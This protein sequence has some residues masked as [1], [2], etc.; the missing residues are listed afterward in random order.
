[1]APSKQYGTG[2]HY[3][4]PDAPL[5]DII[6]LL[7]RDGA[8]GVRGLVSVTDLDQTYDEIKDRMNTDREWEEEFFPKETKR[9][10]G[11]IGASPT[12]TRTQAMNPL[13]QSLCT[14]LLTTRSTFWWGDTRK[15]SVSK[16]YVTAAVAIQIGPG[17]KAQPLHGD[18]YVNHR[19]REEIE[20]WMMVTKEN[21]GTQI[22]P[23]SHLWYASLHLFFP[24]LSLSFRLLYDI[25]LGIDLTFLII[26]RSTSRPTPPDPSLIITPTLEKGDALLIYSSVMHGGGNNITTDNYRL[27]YSTF[28]VR[29]YLRQEENQFLAIPREVVTT[30]DRQT[31]QFIGYYISEPACGHVEQMD[32]IYVLYPEL[33]GEGGPRDF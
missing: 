27:V 3:L 16:P 15:E 28:A 29:G 23:G 22:I 18:S 19:V 20:D 2:L 6:H 4:T 26:A 32:P 9:V 8:V 21:G 14:E 5:D 1:M 13:F 30:L 25:L 10:N 33:L 12:Y 7:K 17:G 24:L 31:Q 11:L